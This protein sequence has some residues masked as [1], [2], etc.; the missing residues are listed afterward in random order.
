MFPIF[1][2]SHLVTVPPPR[3]AGPR[4]WHDGGG[5]LAVRHQ[6]RVRRH[7]EGTIPSGQC[8]DD[9]GRV[10]RH[11]PWVPRSGGG[12]ILRAPLCLLW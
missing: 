2:H 9:G 4:R 8:A 10:W 5:Y 3:I 12:G 6:Q 7:L 1:I 11:H